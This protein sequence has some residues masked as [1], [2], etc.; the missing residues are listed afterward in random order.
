M[1][2]ARRL[3]LVLLVLAATA[4]VACR[5]G[6]SG[7][8][9]VP[10]PPL[11]LVDPIVPPTRPP[12]RAILF[13]VI[14]TLR[15]DHVGAYGAGPDATPA[16]D[17][18]AQRS[19]VFDQAHATSSWTR[20]SIASMLTSRYPGSLR[21]LGRDDAIADDALTVG[22]I[23]TAHGWHTAGVFSNGNASPELGFAQGVAEV[24][25]PTIARG[26]PGD[27]QKFTAEGVT[28]EAV[29]ALRAWHDGGAAAPLFLFVHY[30]DPHDPYL[31]HPELMPGPEPPGRFSGARPEL[32]RADHLSPTEVTAADVARIKYLYE[33]EVRYC[34]HW[35]GELLAALEPLGVADRTMIVLTADHGEGLW[36]HG[37]RGHGVDLYQEQIRVPL[38]VHYA[39]MTAA[40]AARVT[41][42]VSLLDLVPTMLGALGI[43]RPAALEGHDLGPLTRGAAR[44]AALEWIYAEL[45]LDGRSFQSMRVG[46]AKLIVRHG[47]VRP[48]LL[49]PKLFRLDSDPGE[50]TDLGTVD[51]QRGLAQRLGT[52]IE[53]WSAAIGAR[54]AT[55]PHAPLP[56]LDSKLQEQLRGLGYIK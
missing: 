20:S 29:A 3:A 45:D 55:M 33:G 36:D 4:P 47:D 35:V 17:R 54:A 32:D 51:D 12:P 7:T 2:T 6:R 19:Y 25:R 52:G 16:L 31:P 37:R 34:D 44:A 8:D 15:A 27:F 53:R 10:E 24:R 42:P 46:P 41:A 18:L 30:I 23:L 28:A 40:D 22:E 48:E 39:G 13:V 11:A 5:L 14:D 9:D 1:I 50:R 43:E 21:V 56:S 26:Y 49:R 38:L